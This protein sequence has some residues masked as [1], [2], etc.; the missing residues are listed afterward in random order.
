MTRDYA[1][2]DPYSAPTAIVRFVKPLY[3]SDE[4]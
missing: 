2:N 4:C 3:I 1:R